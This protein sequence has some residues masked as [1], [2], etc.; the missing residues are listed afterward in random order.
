MVD[1]ETVEDVM[2]FYA[3]LT[4][5]G[6]TKKEKRYEPQKLVER[7][8]EKKHSHKVHFDPAG[9]GGPR[10]GAVAHTLLWP[11]ARVRKHNTTSPQCR[12][13]S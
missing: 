5:P 4:L 7:L 11:C 2:W 13:G 10:S 9:Y 8:R 3:D 6:H 1:Y 12:T